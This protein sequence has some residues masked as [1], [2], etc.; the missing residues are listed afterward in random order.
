MFVF[1]RKLKLSDL[2]KRQAEYCIAS[3]PREIS[4]DVKLVHSKLKSK[5]YNPSYIKLRSY[6]PIIYR[7]YFEKISPKIEEAFTDK[8]KAIFYCLC[9]RHYNGYWREEYIKKLLK[10][11]Y[12]WVPVF[13]F[14]L[15]SEYVVEIANLIAENAEELLERP[16]YVNFCQQYPDCIDLFRQRA[17]TYWQIYYR[18]SYS[19]KINY[20]ALMLF[21]KFLQNKTIRLKK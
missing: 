20:P 6:R 7:M 8:Q 15:A 12:E 10:F 14:Q 5:I 1:F 19:D 2:K 9:S 3:F 18:H 21:S 17:T 4:E 16:V 11:E 13:V